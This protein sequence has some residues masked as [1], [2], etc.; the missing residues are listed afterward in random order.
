MPLRIGRRVA[1]Q[2]TSPVLVA[3]SIN[4][5]H[6]L[7]RD[8]CWLLGLLLLQGQGLDMP[9]RLQVLLQVL[10]LQLLL[11]LLQLWKQLLELLRCCILLLQDR[12][13]DL[14]PLRGLRVMTE[15]LSKPAGE[16]DAADAQPATGI[17]EHEPSSVM[18]A[19]CVASSSACGA[20]TTEALTSATWPSVTDSRDDKRKVRSI[21]GPWRASAPPRLWLSLS[22]ASTWPEHGQMSS[23][24]PPA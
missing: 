22:P 9:V 19:P 11:L 18:L 23:V 15:A 1:L 16:D 13:R 6:V 4:I 10:L 8:R 12:T 21:W 2:P 20:T 5:R 3:L 14:L 7:R 17:A 24:F